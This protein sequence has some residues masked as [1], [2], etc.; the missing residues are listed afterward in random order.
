MI[1]K[2]VICSGKV[3]NADFQIK[4]HSLFVHSY[5]SPAFCDFCGQ[6]LF[7]LVRQGLK[8][9]GCGVNCHK[10]C[11]YKIPNNCTNTRRRKSSSQGTGWI[12][13]DSYGNVV[14]SFAAAPAATPPDQ[15][16]YTASDFNDGC[17]L[18]SSACS[19]RPCLQ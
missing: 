19:G 14:P 8:C 11:A 13:K 9:E 5:K 6:M 17:Q 15:V 7:G 18:M 2:L 16:E 3:R 4:P 10:R 12:S 1:P